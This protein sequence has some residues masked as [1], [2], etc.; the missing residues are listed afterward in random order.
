MD[1]SLDFTTWSSG[2]RTIFGE[3]HQVW[4]NIMKTEKTAIK[5]I[6]RLTGGIQGGSLL[7]ILVFIKHG[8]DI[9]HILWW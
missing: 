6:K 8:A 1:A 7:S 9:K 3:V 2:W 5:Y 4:K